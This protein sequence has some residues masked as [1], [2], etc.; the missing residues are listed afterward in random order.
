LRAE[1]RAEVR[2]AF[3]ERCKTEEE[4][5]KGPHRIDYLGVRDRLQ[6]LPKS[7]SSEW[8]LSMAATGSPVYDDRMFTLWSADCW[9]SRDSLYSGY[10]I[11]DERTRRSSFTFLLSMG[12]SLSQCV[13]A[14]GAQEETFHTGRNVFAAR[15]RRELDWSRDQTVLGLLS[16]PGFVTG[17][18]SPLLLYSSSTTSDNTVTVDTTKIKI[19]K[20]RRNRSR[21][22]IYRPWPSSLNRRMPSNSPKY[23][24]RGKRKKMWQCVRSCHTS[25]LRSFFITTP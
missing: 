4:L 15:P 12:L 25:T 7:G 22:D 17:N 5:S 20:V 24:A 14:S 3:R 11:Y 6:I 18:S 2:A 1:E 13:F 8:K 23:V 9:A 21:I 19:I 16:G 10:I